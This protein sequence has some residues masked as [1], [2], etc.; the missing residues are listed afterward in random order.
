MNTKY[1]ISEQNTIVG[2][3]LPIN[4]TPNLACYGYESYNDSIA[5]SELYVSNVLA[6]IDNAYLDNIPLTE[7]NII[8][9][10]EDIAYSV[11]ANSFE[12]Y[13][14]KHSHPNGLLYLNISNDVTLSF[15]IKHHLY[16]SPWSQI[17]AFISPSIDE[18][19]SKNDKVNKA[20][21]KIGLFKR[22]GFWKAH[23][24]K[25]SSLDYCFNDNESYW[26]KIRKDKGNVISYIS[27]DGTN[28]FDAGCE[29]AE[30]SGN[31]YIGIHLDFGEYSY[32]NWLYSYH[33]QIF[34]NSNLSESTVPIEY[35]FPNDPTGMT[36]FN[37]F[38]QEYNIPYSLIK[39]YS[40][41][42]DKLIK[43]CI[44]KNMY[45]DLPLN[46]KYIKNRW[47][48]GK[49]NYIHYNMVFGYDDVHSTASI[50]GYNEQSK[51]S[52]S[53]VDYDSL[54]TAF[55]NS[56][57]QDVIF[58]KFEMGYTAEI[59]NVTLIYNL[60]ED[61]FYS[62]DSSWRYPG[63]CIKRDNCSFG[64]SV[65]DCI[66]NSEQNF[67]SFLGDKRIAYFLTEHKRIMKD[68]VTFLVERNI[69]SDEFAS[70]LMEKSKRLYDITTTILLL[71]MKYNITKS[72][73]IKD[74]LKKHL[75]IAKSLDIDLCDNL[76][77]NMNILQMV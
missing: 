39:A 27:L 19:K 73:S 21:Y 66:T 14:L 43:Y 56:N 30:I 10:S 75:A 54:Q 67:A 76:L 62:R 59:L 42:I 36:K 13:S 6:I 28:W 58:R 29:T 74:R 51:V 34:C 33:I 45:L 25:L 5:S 52:T 23:G 16:T 4:P 41:R 68:R 17:S 1:F 20:S 72:E 11:K 69:I 44:N 7:K 12:F 40:I 24:D 65:Y 2:M 22:T 47:A 46:E 61:Y 38:I 70:T 18:F 3:N 77:K 50:L 35:F 63:M 55:N 37:P 71:V 48:Y 9:Y 26:L 57:G 53:T 8:C 15:R 32:Y 60:I 64:L 49:N 31:Y